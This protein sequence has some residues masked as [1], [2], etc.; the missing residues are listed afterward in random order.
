MTAPFP[1]FKVLAI[2]PFTPPGE[3]FRHRPPLRIDGVGTD[4]VMERLGVTFLVPLPAVL[5]RPGG[6]GPDLSVA[7]QGMRDFRPDGLAR[8]N[9]VLRNLLEARTFVEESPARGLSAEDVHRRLREWPDLPDVIG[10][11]GLEPGGRKADAVPISRV[12]DILRMVAMPGDGSAS[13]GETRPVAD[14]I[15]AVI[16]DVLE[17]VFADG[18]FRELE[19]AWRGLG[20]L[21]KEAGDGGDVV[22]EVVSASR[23]TLPETLGALLPGLVEDPPSLILLDIPFDGSA[24]GLEILEETASFA[25]TLLAPALCWITPAFLHIDSWADLERLPF[26]PHHFEEQVFA[27]WRKLKSSPAAR[28]LAVTC[29]RFLAREPY[30]PDDRHSRCR[31]AESEKLWAGPVW[32][33]GSLIARSLR[34]HGWPTRFT[35]WRTIRLENLALHAVSG[36]RQVPTETLISD[37]RLSQFLKAGITPLVSSL[38]RDIAFFP[39]ERTAAGESLRYQLF[40]SRLSRFLMAAKDRL[41]T[42]LSSE[43]AAR[44]I[45]ETL[46]I[47]WARTG[48]PRPPFDASVA[49]QGPGKPAVLRL[50]VEPSRE[51]LPVGGRVDLDL[52]L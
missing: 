11:E 6:P 46:G 31:F 4:G 42:H 38:D 17:R 21:L 30:G 10:P 28:W 2:A 14:R 52:S 13:S 34:R 51:V 8:S 25:A 36:S 27:K 37:D 43:E 29:N 50:S 39:D 35:E 12:D 18:T 15:D 48:H 26:L 19:A 40:V 20:L 33:A 7:L 22:V 41:G 9:P 24:R 49:G 47:F 1:P 32:A 5:R 45:L 44:A 23:E 16:R 3:S